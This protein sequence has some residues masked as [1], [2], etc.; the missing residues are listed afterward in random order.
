[1]A[2]LAACGSTVGTAE[3]RAESALTGADGVEVLADGGIGSSGPGA[4]AAAPAGSGG[5]AAGRTS[6]GA[7][8]TGSA[9][10]GA[11]SSAVG[12]G[13]TADKIYVGLSYAVNSSA[14][15]TAIGAAGITQGD[16][17]ATNQILIDDINARGGIAGRKIEP[18]WHEVDGASTATYDVIDQERCDAWTQDNKIFVAMASPEA[19]AGTLQQCLHNRGALLLSSDLTTSDAARFRR[20]PYY[21]EIISMNLDRIAV[22]EVAALKAQGWFDGW[23]PAAGAPGANPVKVGV[24]TYEGPTWA[25]AVDQSLVPALRAL[26][27]APAAN[28]IIRIPPENAT[29]DAGAIGAATSSAVLRLRG[30][31]VTHVIV[32]DHAA[33]L[34][35]FFMRAADSQ[36]FRPRYGL[37]TQ[38]GAQALMEGATVPARQLI[39]SKGIGW[40][41]PLDIPAADN[42]RDGP[43]SNAER[44]RCLALLEG[45]GQT[46]DSSNAESI[47]MNICAEWWFFRDAVAASGGVLNRDGF[48]AGVG[49]LGTSFLAAGNFANRFSSTQHD[50][51]DAYRHYA[52]NE[53]CTCMRYTS[54]N[55]AAS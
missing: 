44:R 22:A 9:A 7:G 53:Q 40:F 3:R 30:D 33:L 21:V 18:V 1:M 10:A 35:L 20:F 42:H 34:T 8:A 46:F 37:N 41:P 43:Y 19:E 23:N 29:A 16:P 39:G 51:V 5:R 54:G 17:K 27:H 28:N 11:G 31:G 2:V 4:G 55:I 24:V 49:K 45:K 14:A 26:G 25:H 50:G 48:M 36:E 32:F 38:N 47:A 52:F 6:A 12:P 15:N 13:V